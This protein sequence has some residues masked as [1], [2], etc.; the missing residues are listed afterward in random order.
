M[1]DFLTDIGLLCRRAGLS[2]DEGEAL[3]HFSSVIA[4]KS[5]IMGDKETID[6]IYNKIIDCNLGNEFLKYIMTPKSWNM[7]FD[8]E[9][10][11]PPQP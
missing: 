8:G 3:S 2:P 10:G 6:A 7:D 5:L 11:I 4:D 9:N 1:P